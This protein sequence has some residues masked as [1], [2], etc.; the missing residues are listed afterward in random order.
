MGNQQAKPKDIS[1]KNDLTSIDLE[2]H[3][4]VEP[5]KVQA[6]LISLPSKFKKIES[7]DDPTLYGYLEHHPNINRIDLSNYGTG[8]SIKGTIPDRFIR[9]LMNLEHLEYLY[10]YNNQLC[11]N[12]PSELGKLEN[13]KYLN[14]SNNQLCGNIPSELGNLED[15]KYLSLSYN[16]LCGNIP[17]ELGKLENLKSLYLHNNQLCGNIPLELGNIKNLSSLNLSLN[18][19]C[20]NIP[21]EI[22]N[23]KNLSIFDVRNNNLNGEYPTKYSKK[24]G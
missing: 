8:H 21:S 12:I 13:L 3:I 16:Q 5:E 18:Q 24:Y 7:L 17:S 4:P 19:L 9:L 23:I 10:L 2:E 6:T 1:K 22:G 20:G 15:L 11:G 14:L